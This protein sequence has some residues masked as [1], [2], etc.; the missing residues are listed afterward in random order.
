M[1][2]CTYGSEPQPGA[3]SFFTYDEA[4]VTSITPFPSGWLTVSAMGLSVLP[5]E[6][7]PF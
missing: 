6:T 4:F 1:T 2:L 3:P 5:E 7:A